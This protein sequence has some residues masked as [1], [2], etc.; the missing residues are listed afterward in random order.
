ME[1][2]AFFLENFTTLKL[3]NIPAYMYEASDVK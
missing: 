2:R 3:N 1:Q